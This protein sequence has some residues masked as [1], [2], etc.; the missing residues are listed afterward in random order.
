[1][2]VE[3]TNDSSEFAS[4]KESEVEEE[5]SGWYYVLWTVIVLFILGLIMVIVYLLFF[6]HNTPRLQKQ[7]QESEFSYNDIAKDGLND[8]NSHRSA[9]SLEK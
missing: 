3:C 7:Y 4:N 9:N 1:M 8:S 2:D 5:T 6:K